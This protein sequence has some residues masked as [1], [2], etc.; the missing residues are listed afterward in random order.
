MSTPEVRPIERLVS[1]GTVL[2]DVVTRV[3]ALPERG[4]DVFGSGGAMLAGGGY[5]AMAA[6]RRAGLVTVHA[7]STGTGPFGDL[8]RAALAAA[9]IQTVLAPV[10]AV[11]TGLCLVLV[12]PSGERTFV[13]L[14]GAEGLLEPA[15]LGQ[16][17]LRPTDAV[18]VSGYGLLHPVTRSAI[19]A[20]LAGLPPAATL[21]VDPGP[22][23]HELDPVDLAALFARADWWT[24][25]HREATLLTGRA[26]PRLAAAE[27]AERLAAAGAGADAPPRATAHAVVRIGAEG[28]I[29]AAPGH[30][31]FHVSAVPASVVSTNGAGDAHTGSL[32]AA[33]AGGRGP[34]PAL[35]L[36]NGGAM[37]Y[38]LWSEP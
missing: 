37:G 16:V 28:C 32:V 30:P 7:G 11:D 26:D 35:R 25:N 6:A 23:G 19:R 1:F 27:L 18:L 5:T 21:V 20:A 15:M 8:A 17:P 22:L 36:A 9:G 29:L 2:V 14:P 31:P 24:C 34:I 38:L 12:D 33:L 13:T 3:P 4:G 10:P